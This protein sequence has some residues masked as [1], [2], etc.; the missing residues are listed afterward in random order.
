VIGAGLSGLA[1]AMHLKNEGWRVTI[2]EARERTGGRVL[3]HRMPENPELVFELGGEWVG[4]SHDRIIA[5]CH[6]FGIE[7]SDHRFAASLLR[8]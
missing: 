5:L 2:L 6:E 1:A 4:A 8:N 3:S 7:L